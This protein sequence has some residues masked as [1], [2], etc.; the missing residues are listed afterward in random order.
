MQSPYHR[1][2]NRMK[3][4]FATGKTLQNF[5]GHDH[6]H[7]G[8]HKVLNHIQFFKVYEVMAA[9]YGHLVLPGAFSNKVTT[10]IDLTDEAV[11]QCNVA[12][13]K[14]IL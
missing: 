8:T 1:I 10:D 7:C 9:K 3:L 11:V 4:C 13:L 5:K 2:A 6:W 14:I 12:V